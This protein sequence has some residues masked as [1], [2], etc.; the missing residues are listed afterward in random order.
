MF[1][2]FYH[3]IATGFS[4]LINSFVSIAI[5]SSLQW[6]T[7]IHTGHSKSSNVG[8]LLVTTIDILDGFLL[9]L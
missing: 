9:L 6:V 1:I 5:H 3:D 7:V 2:T 4:V 8:W